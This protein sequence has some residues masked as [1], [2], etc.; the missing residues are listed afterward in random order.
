MGKKIINDGT[1][2]SSFLQYKSFQWEC[3]LATAILLFFFKEESL[4]SGLDSEED[5]LAV[6]RV[7]FRWLQFRK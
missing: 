2:L 6:K 7:P 5:Y 4:K 1:I 3:F